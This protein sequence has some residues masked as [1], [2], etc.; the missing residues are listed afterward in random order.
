MADSETLPGPLGTREVPE[1]PP[2]LSLL[3]P[4]LNHL[5]TSPRVSLCCGWSGNQAL[6]GL[7]PGIL[8]PLQLPTLDRGLVEAEFWPP[9]WMPGKGSPTA[10][11]GWVEP[12]LRGMA[13]LGALWWPHSA[14]SYFS[15]GHWPLRDHW[16]SGEGWA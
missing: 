3:E 10:A 2:P 6:E 13:V 1:E 12:V 7:G 4:E 5:A 8:A 9:Q 16:S 11:G 15:T 14:C